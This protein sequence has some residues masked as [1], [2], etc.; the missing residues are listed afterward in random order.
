ML[1]SIGGDTLARSYGVVKKGGIIVS[2]VARPKESELE[3]Q[4][5]RGAS[6]NVDQIQKSSPRSAN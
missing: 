3:K 4:S 5:I 6:L 2:L 1:D